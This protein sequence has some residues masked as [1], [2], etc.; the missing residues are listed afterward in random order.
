M[1]AI[2][3]QF[4]RQIFDVYCLVNVKNE[5]GVSQYFKQLPGVTWVNIDGLTAGQVAELIHGYQIDLLIDLAGHTDRNRLDVMALKPAPIQ[6]TYLGF[7]N[8]TG[9]KTIDYRITDR[10]ADPPKTQQ[11]YT[12]QLIYLPRCF[13]CYTPSIS[14]DQ[15]P[16]QYTSKRVGELITFGVMNK[17]NKH[18]KWTFRAWSEILQKVPHSVLLIKRDIK[19]SDTLRVKYLLKIGVDAQRIHIVDR[20]PDE[21]EYYRLHNQI[22]VCLD[23]FPYSGTTT[24]CD[25]LMMSTPIVTLNLP[26]RHVSNVTTSML[27]NLGCPELVAHSVDEYIQ[28]AVQLAQSPERIANYKRNLRHQFMELMNPIQ[29]AT[30]F[31]H[32]L[33]KIAK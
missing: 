14:L 19:G 27:V 17:I 3:Q 30:D 29:F 1:M 18:N 31:D 13:V 23:T 26:N 10:Q 6:I 20:L 7:P 24:S 16:I 25:S 4:D 9:L 28:I 5:D 22:D 15:L 8:T 32:L 11:K 21:M 33:V 2:L 12:E